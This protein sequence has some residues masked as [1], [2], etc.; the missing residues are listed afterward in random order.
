M[1]WNYPKR[2]WVKDKVKIVIFGAGGMLGQALKPL[3]ADSSIVAP[4]SHKVNLFHEN[5]VYDFLKHEKP[6]KVINLAG[7][8][9]G[10][11]KNRQSPFSFY[12]NNQRMFDNVLSSCLD[13]DI[14]YLL[15]CSST[16]AYPDSVK[17][18]PMTEEELFG[19][20]PSEDNMGYGMAKRNM[21]LATSLAN[22]QYHKKYGII[23]PSNLYG[24]NDKHYGLNS[25]HYVTSLIYKLVHGTDTVEIGGSG[26]PLRQFTYVKD[27][28]RAIKLMVDNNDNSF[29]NCATSENMSIYEIAERTIKA[30]NLNH[31]ILLN[32]DFPD[33]QFR[34]DVSSKKL[35]EKYNFLFTPFDKGI[36]E[37]Y[38][39]YKT[40]K[41]YN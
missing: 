21:V 39:Y 18:Y 8:V 26:K 6:D 16:C 12:S 13:L 24:F 41:K 33:G 20:L 10:I 4:N 29:L 36:K 5:Q 32:P 11:L 15:S 35:I 1:C 3:F 27:V 9:A 19:D 38:E 40:C 37:T 2:R 30:N 25:A 28:A 31:K 22:K 17:N 34:K 7:E 23:I 14:E